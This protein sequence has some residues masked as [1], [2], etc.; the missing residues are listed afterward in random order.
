MEKRMAD[1]GGEVRVKQIYRIRF[2]RLR[3]HTFSLQQTLGCLRN[4]LASAKGRHF[5]VDP[6]DNEADVQILAG[7]L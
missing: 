7:A 6:L 4:W 3:C 2:C 5:F 1:L